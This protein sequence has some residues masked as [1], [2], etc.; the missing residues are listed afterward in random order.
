MTG[1]V[2]QLWSAGGRKGAGMFGSVVPSV[3]GLFLS[4]P[5]PPNKH[6]AAPVQQ[7]GQLQKCLE[8]GVARGAEGGGPGEIS[9]APSGKGTQTPVVCI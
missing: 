4:P 1:A 8:G 3:C 6:K 7:L 5:K 9:L 2:G